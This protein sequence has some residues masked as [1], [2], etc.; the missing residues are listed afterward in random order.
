[1]P[2]ELQRSTSRRMVQ[3]RCN[4]TD[5][6]GR[7]DPS[8]DPSPTTRDLGRF[9]CCLADALH[10]GKFGIGPAAMPISRRNWLI[11]LVIGDCGLDELL[12]APLD[13]RTGVFITLRSNN[14]S[15]I[16]Y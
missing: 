15:V 11:K 14:G 6:L 10:P 9:G 12:P 4:V 7:N 5:A 1:M 16:V 13:N 2:A 8:F 3:R